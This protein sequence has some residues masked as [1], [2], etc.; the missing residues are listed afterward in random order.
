MCIEHK[1]IKGWKR[2]LRE[3]KHA[4]TTIQHVLSSAEKSLLCKAILI[5]SV[6][7]VCLC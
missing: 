2:L 4:G 5:L 6:F 3:K 1:K 7:S